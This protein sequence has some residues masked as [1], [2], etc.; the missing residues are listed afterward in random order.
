MDPALLYEPPFTS[1]APQGPDAL[2][3][4]AEVDAIIHVL[5]QVRS[6]ALAVWCLNR[7]RRK[8]VTHDEMT[9]NRLDS[10]PGESS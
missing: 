10:A 6:T 2:F 5:E 9:E 4:A 7:A 3:S 1:Y 8:I